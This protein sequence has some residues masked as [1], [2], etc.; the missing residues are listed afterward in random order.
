MADKTAEVQE[1]FFLRNVAQAYSL[2]DLKRA[3]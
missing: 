1:K 3:G 2:P